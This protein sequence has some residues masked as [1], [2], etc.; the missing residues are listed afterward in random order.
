MK[1]NRNDKNNKYCNNKNNKYC[2][3]KGNNDL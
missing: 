1:N 3:N 2:N